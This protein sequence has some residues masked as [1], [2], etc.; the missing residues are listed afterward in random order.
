MSNPTAEGVF[1]DGRWRLLSAI[2]EHGS[3][4]QACRELGISYRKAWGD[5]RKSEEELG[6]T[7]LEKHRGGSGGGN[8]SL[9]EDGERWLQAYTRFR[10]D[11]ERGLQDAFN[12]HIRP[13][14]GEK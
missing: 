8:T 11:V 4:Q 7:F 12:G 6:I 1:G 5:L 2:R 13:L 14:L 10:S 9:T 3:L